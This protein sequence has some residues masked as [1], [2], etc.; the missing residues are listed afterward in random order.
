VVSKVDLLVEKVCEK[1]LKHYNQFEWEDGYATHGKII[2][3]TVTGTIQGV[4]LTPE[5]RDRIKDAI[6]RGA[7]L[8]ELD[9]LIDATNG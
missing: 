4:K 9:E 5:Q 7:I 8:L 2:I 1:L 6:D 3:D